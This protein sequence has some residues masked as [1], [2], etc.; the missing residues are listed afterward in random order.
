MTI[1]HIK[2]FLAVCSHDC[3]VTRAAEY[4]HMSQPAVSL[5]L[6]EMEEYY[7]TALFERNGR[8]LV[9]VEAGR[10]LLEYAQNISNLFD[11]MEEHMMNWDTEGPIRVGASITIGSQFMPEYVSAYNAR[12]PDTPVRVLIAPGEVLEEKVQNSELDFA[13]VEGTVHDSR[14][15]VRTYMRDRLALVVRPSSA[16]D[17][18]RKTIRAE[19]M[20]NMKF[21]LREKGSGTREVFDHALEKAGFSIEPI[22]EAYSTTALIKAVEKGIGASVLP[23]RMAAAHIMRGQLTELIPEGLDLRRNFHII[24]QKKRRLSAG[25]RRFIDLCVNYEM[26]YPMIRLTDI[27]E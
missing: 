13:L 17:P 8:H 5:A 16:P 19:E 14:L 24:Y 4:L 6:K 18:G 15:E 1:R 20:R 2:I 23:Y 27:E 21:L 22:W 10:R 12:W 3:N 9:L 26:D 7:G 11:D 25:A